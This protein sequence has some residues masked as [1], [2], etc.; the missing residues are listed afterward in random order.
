MN[1]NYS[2]ILA[3]V[4]IFLLA[5]CAGDI[6]HQRPAEEATDDDAGD[7]DVTTFGME[8]Y[9]VGLGCATLIEVPG[10]YY[11]LIDGGDV[12]EGQ[13][14]ICPDLQARGIDHLDVMEMTHPHYDHA[15][16]LADIFACAQVDEVWT[17]GAES[18]DDGY[19]AFRQALQAWGGPVVVKQEGDVD[20]F[21]DLT[22]TT[23]H[24][25]EGA[26][27]EDNNS[28][29][30]LLTFQ[31]FGALMSTDI[32][33]PA[34]QEVADNYAGQIAAVQVVQI[35]D[36]GSAPY[37]VDFVNALAA[38]YGVLSVGPNED[39][40]PSDSTVNAYVA[41]GLTLYRTDV[42][43]NIRFEFAD[44]ELTATPQQ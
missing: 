32:E 29:V 41:T 35:P 7:D 26:A 27:D 39:G 13:F 22:I 19:L 30:Q 28:L 5:A 16:G 14:T 8:F 20:Q 1:R 17:N 42:N 34:Q 2:L 24:G 40:Y 37:S 4:M 6:E 38:T 12:G 43:G 31:D 23:L 15:G 3:F 18:T 33:Q 25:D 36:H 44:G 9:N 21:G 10:P 11:L